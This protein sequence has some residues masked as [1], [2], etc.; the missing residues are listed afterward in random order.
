MNTTEKIG[1]ALLATRCSLK[2]CRAI[3]QVFNTLADLKEDWGT[4]AQASVQKVHQSAIADFMEL[5]S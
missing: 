3:A 2:E 4:P 5:P 1:L